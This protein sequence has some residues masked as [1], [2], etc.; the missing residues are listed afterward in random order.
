LWENKEEKRETER[1]GQRNKSP[2]C[3]PVL[4]QA[5]AK[6]IRVPQ[7]MKCSSQNFKSSQSSSKALFMPARFTGVPSQ[8]PEQKRWQ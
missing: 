4:F 2:I 6:G 5:A 3:I 1:V 7:F 8:G